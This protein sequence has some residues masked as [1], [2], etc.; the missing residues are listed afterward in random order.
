MID[1]IRAQQ[2]AALNHLLALISWRK[3]HLYTFNP[4]DMQ[5]QSH[6]N[7]TTKIYS[8]I[9]SCLILVSDKAPALLPLV[10]VHFFLSLLDYAGHEE[11]RDVGECVR[12]KGS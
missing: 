8:K 4:N 6:H 2:M 5:Q 1:K 10:L 12:H 11:F 3:C 9:N 7:R